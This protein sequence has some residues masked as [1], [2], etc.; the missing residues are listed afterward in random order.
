[1]KRDIRFLMTIIPWMYQKHLNFLNIFIDFREKWREGRGRERQREREIDCF[2]CMPQPGIE[3][4]NLVMCPDQKWRP[5]PFGVGQC[6]NQLSHT[7]QGHRRHLKFNRSQKTITISPSPT[8][9]PPSSNSPHLIE[10]VPGS[11]LIKLRVFFH[12][13]L[14]LIINIH[15]CRSL[16][17]STT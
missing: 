16:I 15:L 8:P 17:D 1:M 11:L 3:P 9:I 13:H 5:Q 12:S 6:F 14:S 2:P 7:S 4:C 10:R